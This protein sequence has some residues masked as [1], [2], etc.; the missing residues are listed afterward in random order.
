MDDMQCRVRYNLRSL[1]LL[2]DIRLSLSRAYGGV[3]DGQD[4]ANLGLVLLLVG[5]I[6][7]PLIYGKTSS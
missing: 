6:I 7:G 1:L 5:Y 2:V 4:V 3:Q